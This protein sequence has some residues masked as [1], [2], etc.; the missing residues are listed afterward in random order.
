[1]NA[2]GIDSKEA[3]DM[4]SRLATATSRSE[5]AD[6]TLS[7]RMTF[8]EKNSAA[9]EHGESISIDI[10]QDPHNVEMFMPYAEQYGGNSAAAF[11]LL[12]AELARQ[13]LRPNRVF[14]DGTALPTSFD[15]IH[16]RHDQDAADS[17]LS[18]DMATIDC[19][20]REQTT[21]TPITLMN[22]QFRDFTDQPWL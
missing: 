8:A 9:R 20:H 19:G 7:E 13:G 15:D 6:A 3:K 5:R 1:M 14:S 10:A 22:K 12:D 18:P 16:T 2:T 4:S 11:A 21:S 17:R